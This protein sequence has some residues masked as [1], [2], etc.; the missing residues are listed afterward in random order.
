GPVACLT[1]PAEVAPAQ[2]RT[3]SAELHCSVDPP[4]DFFAAP[5]HRR[6]GTQ[7]RLR[8][9]NSVPPDA[10]GKGF[11]AIPAH[12]VPNDAVSRKARI[13]MGSGQFRAYHPTWKV[14]AHSANR[15]V[16]TAHQCHSW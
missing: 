1:T 16:A 11:P 4:G 6:T 13:G 3:A 12:Q 9:S 8:W 10:P 14:V 5:G 15:R 2:R 7:D